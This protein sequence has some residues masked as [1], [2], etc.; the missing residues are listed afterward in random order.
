MAKK[1]HPDVNK[2]SNAQAKYVEIN[3]A[4]ET[5]GNEGKRRIY[6]S[7]GMSSNEQ[8]NSDFDFDFKGFSNFT[9]M[10]RSATN[11]YEDVND[12]KTKTYEEILEE[13]EKFFSLDDEI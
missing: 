9:N 2:A 11:K 6:D 1:Y 10:F 13:Y 4:Y 5:L 8:Q 12:M 7:T 3:E